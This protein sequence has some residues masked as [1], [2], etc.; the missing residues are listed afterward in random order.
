MSYGLVRQVGPWPLTASDLRKVIAPPNADPVD[1]QTIR[2]NVVRDGYEFNPRSVIADR[3]VVMPM[4]IDPRISLPG[5][6]ISINR[7]L[8]SKREPLEGQ[9]ALTAL[10]GSSGLSLKVDP[11]TGRIVDEQF[12]QE[13][14]RNQQ[15]AKEQYDK[16]VKEMIDEYNKPMAK[17]KLTPDEMG[18]T[19]LQGVGNVLPYM[20]PFIGP[21]A[22]M[23][24]N[25]AYNYVSPYIFGN[26]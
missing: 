8:G 25:A 10:S 14:A 3:T 15:T 7:A 23:A 16:K 4:E 6:R 18:G 17:R 13:K 19:I 11:E 9:G 2:P 5:R 21:Y 12:L 26:Q 22:G 24:A 1:F 20:I